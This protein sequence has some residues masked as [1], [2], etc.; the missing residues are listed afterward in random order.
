M[1]SSIF[2]L[3]TF[4]HPLATDCIY[5]RWNY[6]PFF[7]N[8]NYL[9]IWFT[10]LPTIFFFFFLPFHSFSSLFS[11]TSSYIFLLIH[12]LYPATNLYWI[13][14]SCNRSNL[15]L[16]LHGFALLYCN[17]FLIYTSI[18]PIST[19][20]MFYFFWLWIHL[21]SFSLY[22]KCLAFP[23]LFFFLLYLDC[24]WTAS[25]TKSSWIILP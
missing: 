25:P 12:A 10:K 19:A 11:L 14:C 8:W 16:N 13:F 6:T 5:F 21:S 1:F 2:P 9:L 24:C 15:S 3:I 7:H 18:N 22:P 23:L 4:C 20:L 17:G